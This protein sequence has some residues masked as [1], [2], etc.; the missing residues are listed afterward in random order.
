MDDSTSVSNV[1]PRVFSIYHRHLLLR[2]KKNFHSKYY[3]SLTMHLI[4][5]TQGLWWRWKMRLML[6]FVP[7]NTTSILKSMD[8]MII[9]TFKCYYWSNTFPKG[10]AAI[11]CDCS[12]AVNQKLWE[13]IHHPQLSSVKLLSCVR[14]FATPWV[15]AGQAPCPSPTPRVYSNSSPW[16]Q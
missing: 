14:L 8:H 5:I 2:N 13:S 9:L 6:F 15:T 7:T 1:I 4:L 10:I 12:K 11:D 16:S 3:C